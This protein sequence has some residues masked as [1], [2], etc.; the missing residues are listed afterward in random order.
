[1]KTNSKIAILSML[2]FFNIFAFAKAQTLTPSIN[3]DREII[4]MFKRGAIQFPQGKIEVGLNELKILVPGIQEALQ[5]IKVEQF[6]KAFKDFNLSDTL[7]IARTGEKVRLADLSNI[8]KIR[9][10]KGAN[11]IK[12]AAE[13]VRFPE[14]IYAEPNGIVVPAVTPN[15]PH[16]TNGDQW[17]LNQANDHDIDAPEAWDITTG[18]STTKIGIID[19]GVLGT[20]EDLSGKVTG[21]AGWGWNGHGFHV[22]GI[23]AANTNNAMGVAGVDW[24]ARLISQRVDN[25]DDEGTYDAIMDA[26]NAGAD[27]LNNSWRLNPM[28]RY[29]TTV[30][31]AFSNAYKLNRVAVVA[32]GND[33]SSQTQYPAGFGQ[34]IIAVGATDAGDKHAG[35]SNTGN[36]IDV[37]APGV[38]I[39]SCVPYSPYYESWSGTSMV[40]KKIS[41][42]QFR[43]SHNQSRCMG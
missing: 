21:D 3:P 6:I 39:W 34:G 37:A 7:G 27:I 18:S 28:G 17:N 42:K 5:K 9:L 12:A 38:D 43:K 30:R 26:V 31:L 19:G 1:M 29:S 20:H 2:I 4:V 11:I 40:N 22:A 25:T 24:N 8:Y 14:I 15:D 23:A 35:F 36:H 32:M 10:P 16:F 13:L 41:A 33:Y